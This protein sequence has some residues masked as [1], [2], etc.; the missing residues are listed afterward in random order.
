MT[1]NPIFALEVRSRWRM[2]RSF[3]LLLGLTLALGC[4]TIFIYQRAAVNALSAE[5]DP[6]APTNTP[7]FVFNSRASFVG[8]ELFETLAQA[9]ILIWLA[10]AAASAATGIARERERG[11]LEGLQLSAMSARGQI[12]ARFGAGLLLLAALQLVLLPIYSV[13]FLIGGVSPGEVARAFALVG[14]ASILGSALGLWFSARSHRPTSALFGALAT[15]AS[16][17]IA[18]FYC[19]RFSIIY[20]KS[21]GVVSRDSL[22]P[23]LLHPNALLW[24]L[25][26]TSL[27]AGLTPWQIITI[28]G[29]LWILLSGALLWSATRQVN[30]TLAPPAWQ[31]R[32][33][34][35]ERLKAKQAA[36]S[37]RKPKAA[38]KASGALLADLPLDNLVRF[39]NPLLARE[40]RGRFRLRQAGVWV[41][42]MRGVLFLGAASLWIFEVSWLSDAPSRPQMVPSALRV[43]LYGGTLIL[44]AIAATSW[45][46]ERESGTWESLKLSLLAPR[47]ILRAKWLSPLISF[48]YYSAPLWILLPVGAFYV[49]GMASL[50][51]AAIVSSWLALATALG[52][53]ISWRVRNGTA[54]IAWTSGILALLLI[55]LPWLNGLAGLDESLARWRYGV[56]GYEDRYLLLSANGVYRSDVVEHYR[57]S[58]GKG[59]RGPVTRTFTTTNGKLKTYVDYHDDNLETWLTGQFARARDFEANLWAWHPNAALKRTFG[60]RE[61]YRQNSNMPLEEARTSEAPLAFWLS[62]LAPLAVTLILLVLLRRDVRREQLG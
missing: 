37:T 40:V 41:S 51:G 34:W 22:L 19:V 24:A 32:A 61:R 16:V 12:A 62:T 28:C 17:S 36:P 48:A 45:T 39:S 42:L 30:R 57:A 52:L 1:L 21:G 13:A 18:V 38:Q 10:L 44:A 20:M 3:A 59:A 7:A 14:V 49:E 50:M 60:E 31:S 15:V 6:L 11:L 25:S 55:A 47:E 26:D 2:N 4:A 58:T 35:V 29:A 53:W 27:K 5:V 46:R 8:R 54:A 33:L 23:A 56:S 9:N 43:F